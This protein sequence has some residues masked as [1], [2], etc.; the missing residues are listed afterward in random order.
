MRFIIPLLSNENIG[1]IK[2]FKEVQKFLFGG[3]KYFNKIEIN[4]P[5]G[6][7]IS[8][9]LDRGELKIGGPVFL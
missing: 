8:R 3:S 6:P 4:N 1:G 5:G 7:N 2:Y 9:Y